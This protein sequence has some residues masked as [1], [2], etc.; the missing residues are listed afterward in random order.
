MSIIYLH[1]NRRIF[2]QTVQKENC[3][4]QSYICTPHFAIT[5]LFT[6]TANNLFFFVNDITPFIM[7]DRF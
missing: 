2:K 5:T 7:A 3:K 4:N 1:K 6:R